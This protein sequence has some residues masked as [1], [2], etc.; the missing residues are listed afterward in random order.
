[1]LCCIIQRIIKP[2]NPDIN[3]TKM[4][5]NPT[6]NAKEYNIPN[7]MLGMLR[8]TSLFRACH[9]TILF[10]CPQPFP[11]RVELETSW[12]IH[13]TDYPSVASSTDSLWQWPESR[14]LAS[15]SPVVQ[16]IL[17]LDRSSRQKPQARSTQ[18]QTNKCQHEPDTIW[19]ETPT[20]NG[21]EKTVDVTSNRYDDGR[22]RGV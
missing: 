18:R 20:R 11:S 2:C 9:F 19:S 16:C 3:E 17:E 6:T 15:T 4:Q 8:A 5:P 10:P 13:V 14:W 22:K 7:A 21:S 12:V 1:M